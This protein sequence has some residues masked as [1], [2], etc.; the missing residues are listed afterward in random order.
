[1]VTYA[2][3]REFQQLL[4]STPR[5]ELHKIVREQV[6]GGLPYIFRD[7]PDGYD[8]LRTHLSTS[9][10]VVPHNIIIV[11]SAKM[12]FSLSP[13][14]FPRHFTDQSDID[15][16]IVSEAIFDRVWMTM[17]DWHYPRRITGLTNMDMNWS[18]HRRKELYWGW[19]M[20]DKIRYKGLTLPHALKPLRNISTT[21]FNA[22]Q[23]LSR[24]AEYSEIVERSVSG[25]L[26]RTWAHATAYHTDGLRQIREALID[27]EEKAT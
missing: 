7:R 18:V 23:S 9:L 11:G 21:W 25:R 22:F 2:T 20:P 26:Y 10:R 8:V 4:R 12:G 27:S 24:Y 19:F 17:L 13:D 1:M 5:Q 15:V 14:S 16:V 3:A 6:F